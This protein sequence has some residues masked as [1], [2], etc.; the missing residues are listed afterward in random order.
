TL[1]LEGSNDGVNYTTLLTTAMVENTLN[2]QDQS[3]SFANTAAYTRYRLTLGAPFG[4]GDLQ[5]GEISLLGSV[6]ATTNDDCSN[7][8]PVTVGINGGSNVNA[9]AGSQSTSCDQ[10]AARDVWFTFTSPTRGPISISTCGSVLDT[11]LAV[12]NSCGSAAIT[13]ANNTC[14]AGSIVQF[15]ATQGATYL[16]RVAGTNGTTGSFSLVIDDAVVPHTDYT[17]ALPY[18]FNGMVQ[19]GEGGDPD[20]IDGYRSISDRGLRLNGLPGSIEVGLLGTTG[21]PYAVETRA[22]VLDIVHLGDRNRVDNGG[23]A[24]DL[25]PADGDNI[26]VQPSWLTDT[27]QDGPHTASMTSAGVRRMGDATQIGVLYHVSNGG[28][29]FDMTLNFTDGTSATVSLEG[30]DWFGDQ[31]VPQPSPGVASQRQLGIYTGADAVDFGGNGVPLNVVEAVVS[32]QSLAD[33]GLGNVSGRRLASIA[34]GNRSSFVAGYAIF[35]ASIRDPGCPADMDGSGGVD[36]DDVIVFFGLWDVGNV[37]ADFTG[38]GGV[39]SDDVIEFFG[40]W[41]SGC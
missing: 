23:W 20:I 25:E 40:R 33:A 6:G 34:F 18:N 14:G 10:G 22:G 32:T 16:I 28:G 15:N 12:Y 13:C 37:A 41:D 9:T 21:I 19:A 17:I 1:N 11:V 30:P 35:A 2:F 26:G 24:F 27:A 39:D 7:P 36:S 4:G 5:L 31:N 29:F 38:E 3:F 8:T